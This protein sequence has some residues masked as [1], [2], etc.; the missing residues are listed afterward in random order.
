M[1]SPLTRPAQKKGDQPLMLPESVMLPGT[2]MCPF[3]VWSASTASL[4]V[5]VR[6]PLQVAPASKRG[7]LRDRVRPQRGCCR[8]VARRADGAVDSHGF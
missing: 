7:E 3:A 1:F 8:D 4:P 6:W 2:M 5:T